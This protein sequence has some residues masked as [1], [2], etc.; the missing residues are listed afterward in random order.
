MSNYRTQSVLIPKAIFSL[1]EAEIFVNSHFKLKKLDATEKYYRFR[2]LSP[3]YL[4]KQGFKILRNKMLDDGI[5]LVL[6]YKS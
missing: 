2:Q 4:K 5:I 3:E 6:A 1:K